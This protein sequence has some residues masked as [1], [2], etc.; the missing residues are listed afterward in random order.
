MSFESQ[1][2]R[3]SC[4]AGVWLLASSCEN[5][6]ARRKRS[7][8]LEAAGPTLPDEHR[9][10]RHVLQRRV[11]VAA[12]DAPRLIREN[13]RAASAARRCFTHR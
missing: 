5:S 13:G 3:M 1:F 4:G 10:R 2:N 8:E 9:A 6:D 7:C 11:R 12:I